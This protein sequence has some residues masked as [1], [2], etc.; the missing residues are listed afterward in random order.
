MVRRVIYLESICSVL[1]FSYAWELKMA[2][3]TKSSNF[4][5]NFLSE[6]G[7]TKP[8]PSSNLEFDVVI[9]KKEYNLQSAK[10]EILPSANSKSL[11]SQLKIEEL[12]DLFNRGK[13]REV[14]V[15]GLELYEK[16]S[17]SFLLHNIM[18]LSHS[19]F[20][21]LEDALLC[22]KKAIKIKPDFVAAHN[23]LAIALTHL[24]QF[25]EAII[26]YNKALEINPSYAQGYNNLGV[27][28]YTLKRYDE[29]L[30]AY[31]KALKVDPHY[32]EAYNNLGNAL[33]DLKRY[34]EALSAFT[35][36][37]RIKPNYSAAK[38]HRL[39][40]LSHLCDWLSIENI[41]N[42]IPYIGTTEVSCSPFALLSL[43]DSPQRHRQRSEIYAKEKFSQTELPTIPRPIEKHSRIK[44]G[45]F[46]AD[47]HNHATMH[48]IASL[49]E[50]HNKN[51]F[52]IYAYS[53]GPNKNDEMQQRL[54][55]SVEIFQ[56]VQTISDKE[57]AELARKDGID[58]AIDLKGYTQD[59]RVG[60]FSYRAAPIQ[61]TYLGY[62]GTTGSSFIDYII[63][64][65][66]IIPEEA[67]QYYSEKVIYLPHSYQ[68]NDNTRPVSN[69]TFT[70]M[71]VGLP[72]EGFVFCCFNNNY[73][74]TPDEFNIWMRLLTKVDKSVL[75][76]LKGN[77]WAECNLKKEAEKRGIDQRRLIFAEKYTITDHLARHKM[78]NLFL[79]TFIY[80]AHTTASDALRVGLPVLTKVGK[81]FAARVGASLLTALEMPEL[82]TRTP[83]EYEEKALEL[84]KNPIKLIEIKNKLEKKLRTAP[85]F[86]T[87]LFTKHIEY[88]Y[89]EAFRRWYLGKNPKSFEVPDLTGFTV[90]KVQKMEAKEKTE[91]HNPTT[92]PS[93]D[94]LDHLISL[95]K[96]RSYEEII[97]YGEQLSKKYSETN[98]LLNILGTAYASL[99]RLEEGVLAL[100][101]A[102]QIKPNCSETHNN[103]GNVLAYLKRD[104]EAIA[105]YKKSLAI[106]PNCTKTL[107]N[108][109]IIFVDLGRYQE[110]IQ[111]YKDLVRIEP[112][113]ADAFNELGNALFKRKSY[114]EAMTA[115]NNALKINANCG[116]TFY[117]IGNLLKELNRLEEALSAYEKALKIKPHFPE[118]H[119]NIGV[120]LKALKRYNEAISAYER[121]LH[122]KPDY[123]QAYNN[124]GVVLCEL[125][126]FEDAIS[127]YNKAISIKK[128][129][130]SAY[131]NLGTALQETM[132][133]QQALFAY[134]RA[135]EFSPQFAEAYINIGNT[136]YTT[137]HYNEAVA[138]YT[139]A[140]QI[141]PNNAEAYYN[142]GNV[143]RDLKGYHEAI[144][145]YRKAFQLNPDYD[146]AL[147]KTLHLFSH[148]CDWTNLSPFLNKIPSLGLSEAPCSPFSLL[149]L[150]DSPLRHRKRSANY[151]KDKCSSQELSNFIRP[152]SKP[153][154]LK[155]GYFSADFH[156]HATMHLM[157]KLFETHDKNKFTLFCYSFGPETHDEMQN[158]VKSAV[159]D[160]KNVSALSDKSVAEI[161][162]KDG[163]DI[164]VDLKGYTQDSREGIFSFRAAPIQIN[165]LGYPGTLGA[166]YIDYII[167]DRTLIPEEFRRYYSEKVIYLPNTYQ[168]NDN[169]RKISNRECTRSKVGLPEEG[170]VFCCFNNNYKI[171][172]EEFDI[173][174]RLLKK[175]EKS[176]LW[177]LKDNPQA[178]INLKKEAQNRGV[179]PRRLIFA[180]RQ[181]LPDHLLRHRLA[182]LFLDTFNYNAHTTSS[183]A[184]WAGLPVLTKVGQGFAARVGASLLTAI[185]MPELITRSKEEYEA[186]AI[187][188]A[189]DTKKIKLLKEKLRKNRTASPLFN[190]ELF[191]QHL[192]KAYAMV[193]QQ[194]M[195]G[196][197]PEV[198]DVP[199]LKSINLK[200]PE[201]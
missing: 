91:K 45:Y 186:K 28:F 172:P 16:Y 94:E 199:Y 88:T 2:I 119:N 8:K 200:V 150:E 198:I 53:Y 183:D 25:D 167:A 29:A 188:L 44:I 164:A 42:E 145:A 55:K 19:A 149:A 74:I 118:A 132:R 82:I 83:E 15:N 65:K 141:N 104:D 32:A 138:A 61:M 196:K 184:L 105:S 125:K 39:H 67:I 76:L 201:I 161:A 30:A 72:E 90:S 113:N 17:Q 133:Y 147:A 33:L 179:D 106:K 191:T 95:H 156:T 176:V 27:V 102:S 80:N 157:A 128:D 48:L 155:I 189:L 97:S 14:L 135:L 160:F 123:A 7:A 194:W 66:S 174:M 112:Y 36:A 185:Q 3:L 38:A 26:C 81:G 177:L 142:Y 34:D 41:S 13:Y 78:A 69:K 195:Q 171:T 73:K 60:I 148:H 122:I 35:T 43:E 182:D 153:K 85:L 101:K 99:G 170:F 56:D 77:S 117:N 58:I 168:V 144:S 146:E 115:Y 50:K 62:P 120:T 143:F 6:V 64:D 4:D 86:D 109:S 93:K 190:T 121:A 70:R 152:L 31:S 52:A 151:A 1:R 40:L 178:E 100:T 87:E 130:A 71:E 24:K 92:D 98:S 51:R 20:L 114:E 46:S 18:G 154:T 75:W 180:E 136:L 159:H 139:N 173:W 140:I 22:Y 21:N 9:S 110:A 134:K 192:E 129:Y 124:M 107:K 193:Y 10:P 165:Y 49:F 5:K 111:T 103:L 162:R 187:E 54:K 169:T 57:I 126:R 37:V 197:E 175:V 63:A 79:D 163:I 59:S 108:L 84:A 47:F 11:A 127:A 181:P 131:N 166:P 89:E 12:V 96:S 116:N 158:R 23:N 68:V 137:K